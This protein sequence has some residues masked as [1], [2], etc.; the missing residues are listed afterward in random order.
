MIRELLAPAR[1]AEIGIAAI[2]CGADAVYIAGPGFGARQAAGNSVEDIA[3]LCR[4]AHRFGARIFI[5][6][7]TILFDDELD[8]ARTL[9]RRLQDAGADAFI[10]QDLAVLQLS[11]EAGVT[12]PLH[13]STQ[14]AIRTPEEARFYESLG[15][16]RLVLERELSLDQIRAIRAAVSCELEAFVHGALCVC[17]SGNCYLSQALAGRSANRGACVQACRSRYDLLDGDGRV[18]VRDKALL[19]LKDLNLED[20]LPDL[21]DAGICSFKIEGRL[22]N[23]SYVRNVV[24]TYDLALQRLGCE[25]A[26]WGRTEGGF[27]PDSAKTFNRGYT[28]LYLDG[29]RGPWAAMDMPKSMGEPVGQVTGLLPD[30]FRLA[31]RPGVELANGDGFAFDAGD[32]IIG[33]RGDVCHGDTVH[34]KTVRGLRKGMQVYRN[35]SVAFE[36]KL[37]RDLPRRSLSVR[38]ALSVAPEPD[39][40]GW[41]LRADAVCEDGREVSCLGEACGQLAQDTARMRDMLEQGIAKTAGDYR[42]QVESLSGE[43]LPLMRAADI[44]ALRR[45]LAEALDVQPCRMKPLLNLPRPGVSGPLRGAS[46]KQNLSNRLSKALF[47]PAEEAWECTPKEGAELMRTRYCVRYELGLCPRHHG[48]GSNA[49]LYLRNNGRRLTLRFDC[50]ACEMTVE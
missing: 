49:P 25:R 48:S 18:L 21:L 3:E 33:L 45:A 12:V 38:V 6:F 2:G 31:L 14:C 35:I 42:F 44:N 41:R 43:T 10:V 29:K 37:A 34:C 1:T 8:E 40:R 36:K 22:K 30:G 17:Y 16:S 23:I 47:S 28:A 46:Y 15:F 20:R 9:L 24:R 50:R 19:S 26:S 11:R 13:A 4:Y 7:N 39:A 5:T 27:T 32:E